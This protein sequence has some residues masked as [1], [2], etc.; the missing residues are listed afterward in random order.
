MLRY[1]RALGDAQNKCDLLEQRQLELMNELTA[2]VPLE[3][4]TQEL[5]QDSEK[6]SDLKQRMDEL[7]ERYTQLQQTAQQL[8]HDRFVPVHPE[9]API[10][11]Q[12]SQSFSTA[13]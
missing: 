13:V 7:L 5:Q 8:S 10:C 2:R 11:V 1:S 12:R 6:T 3:H 9:F 4:K